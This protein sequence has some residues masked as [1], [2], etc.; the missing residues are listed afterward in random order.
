MYEGR[1][2]DTVG[3]HARGHNSESIGIAFIGDFRNRKPNS[4]ALDAAKQLI[5]CGV[6]EVSITERVIKATPTIVEE[7]FIFYI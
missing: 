5:S 3:A 7:A 1:G 2:W 6:S 4:D